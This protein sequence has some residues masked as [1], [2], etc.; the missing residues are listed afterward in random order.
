M[1]VALAALA[2]LCVAAPAAA[3]EEAPAPVVRGSIAA[4]QDWSAGRFRDVKVRSAEVEIVR[5]GVEIP[6]TPGLPIVAGD[7]VRTGRGRVIIALSE[8]GTTLVGERSQARLEHDGAWV[9]RLGLLDFAGTGPV[10][11]T[12]D[13]VTVAADD[14]DFRVNRTIAGDGDVTVLRGEPSLIV[15][16]IG[17]TLAAGTRTTFTQAAATAT[18]PLDEAAV[19][20]LVAARDLAPKE[21]SPSTGRAARAHLRI[22][23]GVSR[24]HGADFGRVGVSGRIR[25]GGAVFFALGG[26]FHA[27]AVDDPDID[28]AFVVPFHVGL[29]GLGELPRGFSLF[30]GVDFTGFVGEWCA[31]LGCV[32]EPVFEPG[33]RAML[34]AGLELTPRVGLDLTFG[35]GVVRRVVPARFDP[36]EPVV[37]ELQLHFGVGVF[38]LL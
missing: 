29:R 37:P 5:A 32:D 22:D 27:R 33:V 2:L 10:R 36:P 8:G 18:E 20:E 16:G 17:R 4:L 6:A 13:A 26:G 21:A 12:V 38:F 24:L 11:V 1:R 31:G 30:G 25:L 14:A 19:A 7:A 3:E 35:A 28:A 9:H 15:G 34:G 23:G